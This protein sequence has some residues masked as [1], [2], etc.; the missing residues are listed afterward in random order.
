[1]NKITPRNLCPSGRRE[2]RD[3]KTSSND[4][5]YKESSNR[6]QGSKAVLGGLRTPLMRKYL[7]N[8]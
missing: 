1:M 3:I 7:R 2:K 8:S 6:K 5:Y 4:K